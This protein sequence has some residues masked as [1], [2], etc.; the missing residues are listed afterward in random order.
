M[1]ANEVMGDRVRKCPRQICYIGLENKKD[2]I[3]LLLDY[4][5]HTFSHNYTQLH[6]VE[7]AKHFDLPSLFTKYTLSQYWTTMKLTA[8][9]L[10]ISKY[11]SAIVE[12]NKKNKS[13]K[14]PFASGAR[15]SRSAPRPVLSASRV[16]KGPNRHSTPSKKTRDDMEKSGVT[17]TAEVSSPPVMPTPLKK[18][19]K[20]DAAKAMRI[21]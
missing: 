19:E 17:E 2:H 12:A 20:P 6:V 14:K 9:A 8:L 11:N 5:Q 13:P 1:G 4:M 10:K 3:N 18:G 21:L 7:D 16:T 15:G